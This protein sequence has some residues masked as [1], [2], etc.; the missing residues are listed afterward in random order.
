MFRVTP[1]GL[2]PAS[3][4]TVNS[5]H[6]NFKV[7]SFQRCERVFQQHQVGETAACP[8]IVLAGYLG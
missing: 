4:I 3:Q 2:K 8:L 6:M 7:V 5:L 1:L